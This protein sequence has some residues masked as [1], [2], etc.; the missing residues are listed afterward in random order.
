MGRQK[1]LKGSK[2]FLK[3]VRQNIEINAARSDREYAKNN[4]MSEAPEKV[5]L[6][7]RKMFENAEYK[8]ERIE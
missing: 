1:D 2:D 7:H 4:R 6:Y 3:L 8:R 5:K